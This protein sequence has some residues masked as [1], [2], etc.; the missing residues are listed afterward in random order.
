LSI[1]DFFVGTGDI[2]SSFLPELKPDL[3]DLPSVVPPEKGIEHVQSETPL[4][5]NTELD[6][7]AQRQ[8]KQALDVAKQLEERPLA[9]AQETVL[10]EEEQPP[11]E[12]K[13]DATAD[14][15]MQERTN[16]DELDKRIRKAV[17]NDDDRELDRVE[18]ILVDAH[19]KFYEMHDAR[20]TSRSNP[21]PD[22]SVSSAK[23]SCLLFT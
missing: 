4:E 6:E 8:E 10:G 11:T 21:I 17:L 23:T 5:T 9:K 13:E 15:N 18:A 7:I 20:L 2:N 22:I 1:V 16:L 14:G 19:R 3:P 12:K